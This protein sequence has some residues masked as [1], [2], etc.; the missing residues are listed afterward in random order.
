M[1]DVFFNYFTYV[2][3][4]W[5]II[6]LKKDPY[7]LLSIPLG[8]KSFVL[9]LQD[10]TTSSDFLNVSVICNRENINVLFGVFD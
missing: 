5:V 1:F 3:K 9:L 4:V 2:L 7:I 8:P 6:N 10:K